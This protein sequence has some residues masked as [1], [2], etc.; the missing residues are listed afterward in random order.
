MPER[1]FSRKSRLRPA[2][3]TAYFQHHHSMKR[4]ILCSSIFAGSLAFAG[5][6]NN[7]LITP[8]AGQRGTEI[9]VVLNGAR[10]MDA[11]SLLFNEPGIEVVSVSE[12]DAGKFKAKLK[13]AANARLGEY[14]FRAVTSS[15]IADTRLFYVTPYPVQKEADE[16][17]AA[18]Y[19]VQAVPMGVTIYGATPGEDQDHFEVELKKGQRL[20][21]EVV[22]IRLS[23]QQQYDPYMTISKADGTVLAEMDDG[24]F[25]RQDP[26]LS[27]IAPEDGKYRVAVKEATNSGAGACNYLLHIGNHPRPTVAYPGGGQAGTDV[28]VQ[29]LG[30]ASGPFEQTVKLPATPDARIEV[31]AQKDGASA[32][33]ANFLRVSAYGNVLE[34]EPNN[35]VAK[36]T[37]APGP[38]PLAFNGIIQEK[39]DVDFFK[40][41]A[42]KGGVFDFKVHA[43]SL[44]SPLDSVLSI[45][46]AKGA[47]LAAN[48]DQ[49]APDSVLSKWTVPADGDYFLAVKDQLGRGG[50]LFTY[51]VEV[52]PM[53]A[54]LFA[55]LPE[56]VINSSQERR[57]VPVPK[58]N[59]YSTLVRVRRA[60]IVGDVVVEPKDLPAGVTI[61]T[62]KMDKSVDTIPMVFE[63]KADAPVTQ[64]TFALLPKLAEPPAG[65]N[66]VSKID[67]RVEV[68]ENGNQRAYYGVDETTLALAVTDE[69]PVNIE[70][71]QPKV[72]L[73]Q[74]GS[75]NLKVAVNRKA[76]ADGKPI[77]NGPVLIQLLFTPT[78]LG[79]PG[80]VTIPEGQNEGA[81]TISAQGDA[82][83]AKWK[84]AVNASVDMG[85]GAT[86]ISTGLVD[87]EV[88]APFVGATLVR[89][90]VDQGSEGSMILKLDQK[91]PFEGKAKVALLGL[92]QGVTA[93][94]KEITKDDKD[95]K[96]VL[97][98]TPEAQVGQHKTVIASFTLMKDGEPM[99]TTIA[100]GGILRVDK[101]TA[102]PKVANAK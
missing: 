69:V 94:E 96:F 56:M 100:S 101:G 30:D 85:K 18:P 43:R 83:L 80:V 97:K 8:G 47:Q 25:T 6:P 65:A 87:L 5:S 54:G 86:W 21:A 62:T 11:R 48:D 19:K 13:I 70:L 44:R 76:G 20:S 63:A 55:Y 88:A 23:T 22:G 41:T 42:V 16:E 27:I 34:A 98:A 78:K 53:Q 79:Q 7:S 35:E 89:T 31:I 57:A 29:M 9:E 37:P 45:H 95:V 33:Q 14:V 66:V 32:P 81:I 77:Y 71:H 24:S 91:L 46:D 59:R 82:P 17:K 50:P 26:A 36:A 90:Y 51:R 4:F 49:G 84:I 58:G 38:L 60:D 99:V 39:G 28:K 12:A 1:L 93:E 102:A 92:P 40:F 2:A 64:K 68:T 3:E 52:E 61:A 73:L 75:M 74:S 72:P 67:H 10:L 15:G